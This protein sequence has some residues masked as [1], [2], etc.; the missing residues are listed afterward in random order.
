MYLMV[1]TRPDLAYCSSL[2]RLVSRYMEY[3]RKKLLGSYKVGFRYL[4]GFQ[5][6]V[7]HYK[8]LIST[9]LELFGY[10]RFRLS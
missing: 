3:P 5:R 2:Q 7:L 6:R 4:V 10:G 1:F 8:H 9:D